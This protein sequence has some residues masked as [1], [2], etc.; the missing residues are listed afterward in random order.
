[1]AAATTTKKSSNQAVISVIISTKAPTYG[2]VSK[3][4]EK[5]VTRMSPG[6]A[7]NMMWNTVHPIVVGH[8]L[9]KMP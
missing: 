8:L 5:S 6:A 7:E 9:T 3:I 2:I 4:T 1:M